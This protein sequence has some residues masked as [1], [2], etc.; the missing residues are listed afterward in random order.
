MDLQRGKSKAHSFPIQQ[1]QERL[2]GKSAG[3][4]PSKAM[5][6]VVSSTPSHERGR[7]EDAVV[8]F[9]ERTRKQLQQHWR[10]G[11]ELL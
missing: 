8:G 3:I 10:R 7:K 4:F 5:H 9:K 11:G 6:V 1:Q 2:M